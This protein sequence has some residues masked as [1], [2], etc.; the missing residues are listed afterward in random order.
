[1]R[2][3]IVFVLVFLAFP[4][5]AASVL[6][7]ATGEYGPY[8]GESIE[9][10]GTLPQVVRAV[11]KEMK[12]EI[13]LEFMP[14]K[15][16]KNQVDNNLVAGAFPWNMNEERQKKY[17]YSSPIQYYRIFAFTNV[18]HDFTNSKSL[19][20]K[21]I[22]LPDGWDLAP[23][24][25]LIEKLKLQKVSPMTIDSCFNMLALKRVDIVFMNELVGKEIVHR[26]FGDKSHIL[27]G[28]KNYFHKKISMHYMISKTYPNAKK[29]ITD[30]NHAL[31]KIKKN[32]VYD[33]II[34]ARATCGTC[35]R[36]GSL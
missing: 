20:G 18:G 5:Q 28:E 3:L 36:L 30:F 31:E 32:G 15:R 16:V 25:D 6:R 14:W 2:T 29:I 34:G 17:Y 26:L 35:N 23:Y 27:I 9:N 11:F 10:Q 19:E 13:R 12:Q 4:L 22:C 1:M 33:S 24:K 8:S 21:S 7:I